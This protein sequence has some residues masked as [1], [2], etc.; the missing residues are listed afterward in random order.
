[1]N[2][3]KLITTSAIATSLYTF[4]IVTPAHAIILVNVTGTAGSGTT[5]WSFSG[6]ATVG[7][8]DITI[9]DDDID[10]GSGWD[11]S[12]TF[13]SGNNTN[14]DFTSGNASL[15]ANGVTY[16]IS[17]VGSTRSAPN[18]FFGIAIEDPLISIGFYTFTVGT[19]LEFNGTGIAPVDITEFQ[20]GITTASNW[21]GN[22]SLIEGTLPVQFEVNQVPEPLTI[23]GTIAMDNE[24]GKITQIIETEPKKMEISGCE[25]HW[26]K[27]MAHKYMFK[28][29][30]MFVHL[31]G[32]LFVYFC[33]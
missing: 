29:S 17:G 12:T 7:G 24:N 16:D 30:G 15:I 28:L 31:F 21:G 33:D 4:I 20:S 5:N 32:H 19:T 11:V 13:Y 14:I 25:F 9:D 18:Q 22:P 3:Q 27:E 10:V 23:L 1:M 2:F 26:S 6:S 8:G